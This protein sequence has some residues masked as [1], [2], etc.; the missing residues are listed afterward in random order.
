MEYTTAVNGAELTIAL[1]GKLDTET[2][3]LFEKEIMP[4]LEGIT[5]LVL[6]FKNLEYISSSGLRVLLTMKK[7]MLPKNGNV[8]VTNVSESILSIFKIS[9]FDIL[10]DIR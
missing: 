7:A 4:R 10:L 9:G 5:S 1:D 8:C 3:P 2:A 6:D